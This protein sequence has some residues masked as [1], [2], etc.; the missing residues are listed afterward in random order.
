MGKRAGV[1]AFALVLALLVYIGYQGYSTKRAGGTGE[2]FSGDGSPKVV[3]REDTGSSE[4]ERVVYPSS[5]PQA[6]QSTVGRGAAQTT[7]SQ[8]PA[9]ANAPGTD[10]INPN[11]ADGVRFGGSGRYQL[12][13]QG[14]IT[15]RLDT[16]TGRTCII[17][18]TD[19]QWKKPV[20]YRNGCGNR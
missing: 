13:R 8:Q 9:P 10:T 5:P 6:E 12:Y 7:Q 11:P 18:A 19:E 15:W 1:I 20:V 14:D 4:G 16:E 17:F 3:T 2:V